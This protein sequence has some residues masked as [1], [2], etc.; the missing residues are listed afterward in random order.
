MYRKTIGHVTGKHAC[1]A[2]TL[3]ESSVNKGATASRRNLGRPTCPGIREFSRSSRDPLGKGSERVLRRSGDMSHL[4]SGLV[5]QCRG[6]QQ[7]MPNSI[8]IAATGLIS[9][10]SHKRRPAFR[11]DAPIPLSTYVR[12]TGVILPIRSSSCD[13]LR[14]ARL[15]QARRMSAICGFVRP[16]I[17]SAKSPASFPSEGTVAGTQAVSGEPQPWRVGFGLHVAWPSK[18]SLRPVADQ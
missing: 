18:H 9:P 6:P 7:V 11:M 8:L 10:P 15:S 17:A 16:L 2:A 1:K 12:A 14:S 13:M 3:A 4:M 5:D